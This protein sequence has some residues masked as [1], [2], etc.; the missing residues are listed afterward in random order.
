MTCYAS[1]KNYKISELEW[2]NEIRFFSNPNEIY[3]KGKTLKKKKERETIYKHS[4]PVLSCIKQGLR[5]LKTNKVIR[6]KEKMKTQLLQFNKG[7]I[8]STVITYFLTFIKKNEHIIK[9][10]PTKNTYHIK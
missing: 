6:I 8:K 4:E 10:R 2:R 1:M 7:A 5:K 9:L 3:I